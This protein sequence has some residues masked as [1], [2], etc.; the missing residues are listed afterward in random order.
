MVK[1]RVQSTCEAITA[2]IKEAVA[3]E[4]NEIVPVEQTNEMLA[5]EEISN[6]RK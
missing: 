3:A 4:H 1:D 6:T 2:T 5:T